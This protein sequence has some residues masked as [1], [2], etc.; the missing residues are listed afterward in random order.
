MLFLKLV[1][2]KADLLK[3]CIGEESTTHSETG[4]EAEASTTPSETGHEAEEST[5]HLETEREAEESTTHP[6]TEREAEESTTHHETG[7]EAEKSTAPPETEREATTHPETGREAVKSTAPPETER[8]AEESTIHHETGREAEKSTVPPEIGCEAEESTLPRKTAEAEESAMPPET[9]WEAEES[10]LP[11][12]TGSEA[13]EST[14]THMTG[15]MAKESTL[16]PKTGNEAEGSTTC[17]VPASPIEIPATV[18]IRSPPDTISKIISTIEGGRNRTSVTEEFTTADAA[19]PKVSVY[20]PHSISRS[21]S[22]STS[23]IVLSALA[24]S[25]KP[26]LSLGTKVD[27]E[28]LSPDE[29][30]LLDTQALTEEKEVGPDIPRGLV[31][32]DLSRDMVDKQQLNGSDA[33][34][35]RPTLPHY[36]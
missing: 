1:K 33:S 6:E 15:H 36:L 26:L 9:G 22:S 24:S 12:K 14:T 21:T 32:E 29:L 4:H 34:K 10:T 20:K 11:P 8:E 3:K 18:D 16:P 30:L 35:P 13:E 17:I 28:G 25:S 19:Q 5:M 23:R 7:R 31:D 2:E 27:L